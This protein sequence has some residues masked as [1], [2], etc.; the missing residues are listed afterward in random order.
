MPADEKKRA[1]TLYSLG[2]LL[3]EEAALIAVVLWLLPGFGINFPV[4]LLIVFMV[5]WAVYSCL[6]SRLVGKV[7]GKV[8][9]VGPEALISVKCATTTPLL[10][11]GYVRVGTEL[12]RARSVAGNIEIGAKVVIVGIKRLTLLVKLST[13]TS[14]DEG[15]R[16][17]LKTDVSCQTKTT[18]TE[19]RN[20]ERTPKYS[21]RGLELCA[22]L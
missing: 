17:T 4:W 5:A 20:Q 18:A 14:F 1:Y 19:S 12:W 7:I 10:P 22:R 6:T 13:D 21:Y 15:Q 8:A 11:G 3:F 16:I 2:R 9:A